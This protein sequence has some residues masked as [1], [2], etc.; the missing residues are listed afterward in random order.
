MAHIEILTIGD[1]LLEG[2]LIDTNAGELSERLVRDG[3]DVARHLSVGDRR[4]DI[5]AALRECTGRADAVV[6]TG[7]LGPT[8]DDLTAAC[9]AE[10]LGLELERFPEALEHVRRFYAARDRDM[11]PTNEKQADLPSGAVILPNPNG[12]AV[13]FRL[14]ADGCRLFFMPGVPRELRPMFEASVLPELRAHLTR[15]APQ[16]GTLK[17]FGIGESDVGQAL[18]GLGEDLEPPVRLKVQYRVT[19]PEIQV[20]LLLFGMHGKAAG[21]R[22]EDLVDDAHQRLGQHVFALDQDTAFP[23]VVVEE[24]RQNQASLAICEGFTA[25]QLTLLLHGAEGAPEVFAGGEIAVLSIEDAEAAA[26]S[27]R[28]RRG[29]TLGLATAL[30]DD[31]AT[32][33]VAVASGSGVSHR[34]LRFP[35]DM[36]RLRRLAAYVA[37]AMVRRALA[38]DPR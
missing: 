17:V 33:W 21:Q 36:E 22:L 38:T 4:G 19:F 29:A 34:D 24:L 7:G 23:E 6:V 8:S 16:V 31:A 37:L 14:E 13:G 3:F 32:V 2:R 5:V 25:G 30:A 20:R 26:A 15:E 28:E 27:I 1:E 18:Q 12:T 11:A 10:A 35:L 9:A